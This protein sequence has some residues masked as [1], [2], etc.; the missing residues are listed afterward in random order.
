M[1]QQLKQL[2]DFE[3]KLH[4][5]NEALA[6]VSRQ[7]ERVSELNL[8][9]RQQ[10]ASRFREAQARWEA[11]TIE[12]SELIRTPARVVFEQMRAEDRSL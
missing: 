5:V 1:S 4:Q 8:Q 10:L 9:D 2:Q 12:I 6:A 11:V 3:A 7:L